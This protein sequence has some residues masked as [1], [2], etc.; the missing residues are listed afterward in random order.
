MKLV[1]T[2]IFLFWAGLSLLVT[3]GILVAPGNEGA[4][5]L[6]GAPLAIVTMAVGAG[7]LWLTMLVYARL[8]YGKGAKMDD[9]I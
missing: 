7:G 5:P 8:R 4:E 1:Q 3:Q 2:L 6:R 9:L